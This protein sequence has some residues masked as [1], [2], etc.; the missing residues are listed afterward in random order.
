M[1][2]AT[3]NDLVERFGAVELARLTTPDGQP[4]DVVVTDTAQR[5]LDDSTGVIDS[6]LRKRYATPMPTPPAEIVR[7][8]AILARYDLS[9]GEQKEPSEQVR[10]QRKE[11]IDWLDRVAK[12]EVLL[13]GALPAG[14]YSYAKTSDRPA[15][16]GACNSRG[17]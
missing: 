13:D 9:F 15:T 3:I 5:A 11:V 10:L 6:Y 1:S 8:C 7:A 4:V 14:D 16:F 2:Y 17:L 12:G